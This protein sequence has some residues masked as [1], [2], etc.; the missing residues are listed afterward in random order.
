MIALCMAHHAQ[1]DGG[2]WSHEQLHE[3]KNAAPSP[4]PLRGAFNWRR[5]QLIVEASGNIAIATPVFLRIGD[6]D[7]VWLTTDDNGNEVLN[8]DIWDEQGSILFVDAAE[9]VAGGRSAR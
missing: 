3:M 1:A 2:A 8:L 7:I 6:R 4:D 5:E 9:R